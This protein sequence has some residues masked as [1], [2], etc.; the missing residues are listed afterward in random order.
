MVAQLR[1][2]CRAD[3]AADVALNMGGEVMRRVGKRRL[4]LKGVRLG[5]FIPEEMV[6][7]QSEA[8]F[9][10]VLDSDLAPRLEH[11][12]SRILGG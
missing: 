3:G 8:A 7:G 11:E 2:V 10:R 9:Y 12:L 4:P 6:K 5:L 1:A